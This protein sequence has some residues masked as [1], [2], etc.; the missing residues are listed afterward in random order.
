MNFMAVSLVEMIVSDSSQD[1]SKDSDGLQVAG[2]GSG[3]IYK[4]DG[5]EAYI[6]TNNHV[7]DGAKK[8]EIMLSDGSKNLLV[9]SLVKI[10]TL[11]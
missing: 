2:E 5:K 11:T 8:L 3:V 7:V 9:N 4:K 6:V 10:L 1:K